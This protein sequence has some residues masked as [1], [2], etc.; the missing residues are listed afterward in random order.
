M[1]RDVTGVW[2][3]VFWGSSS[4]RLSLLDP[5]LVWKPSPYM[6]LYH[7]TLYDHT[8][9]RQEWCWCMSDSL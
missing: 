3:F 2:S 5:F 9:S 8:G 4:L 7:P 6:P 1:R